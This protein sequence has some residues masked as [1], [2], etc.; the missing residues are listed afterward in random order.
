[1]AFEDLITLILSLGRAR[2]SLSKLILKLKG[3]EQFLCS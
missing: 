2:S 3:H 1:M